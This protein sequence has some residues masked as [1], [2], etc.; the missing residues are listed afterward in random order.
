MDIL[1]STR[2]SL[3]ENMTT[4]HSSRELYQTERLQHDV[5]ASNYRNQY[6]VSINNLP[7]FMMG[8]HVER[9]R[10]VISADI[11][12]ESRRYHFWRL[13][14][15]FL[16]D[17]DENQVS[18]YRANYRMGK[19]AFEHL[20]NAKIFTSGRTHDAAFRSS[21]IASEILRHPGNHFPDNTFMIG[22]SAYPLGPN[23]IIPFPESQCALDRR[24]RTFNC[25]HSSTRMAIERAFGV[26]VAR[27][28]FTS[29]YIYMLDQLKINEVITGCCIL[30]NMCI[31][32]GDTGFTDTVHVQDCSVDLFQIILGC[33]DPI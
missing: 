20:A 12:R 8:E 32:L 2:Q 27:W 9:T 4:I 15:P 3:V 13:E 21:D 14:H 23:L 1:N 7:I 10:T 29:K 24:K 30:H 6:G 5:I 28:R 11:R 16:N 19:R 17:N 33:N 26:L 31:D 18:S 22:D 25:V